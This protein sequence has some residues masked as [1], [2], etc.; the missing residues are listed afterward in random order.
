MPSKFNPI[1]LLMSTFESS[2]ARS[3]SPARSTPAG[4]GNSNTGVSLRCISSK[5]A[6]ASTSPCYKYSAVVV[7]NG[8][9]ILEPFSSS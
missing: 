4:F 9:V 2:E 1:R 7:G 6:A 5:R 8:S 3:A